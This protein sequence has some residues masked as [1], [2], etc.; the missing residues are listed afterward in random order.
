MS[1]LRRTAGTI[2]LA[3][4]TTLGVA[5]T[6]ATSAAA[7]TGSPGSAGGGDPYFPRAG[8][9]GYDVSHYVVHIGYLPATKHLG[10]RALVTARAT[11]ALSRFDLD[12]RRNLR[13]SAVTVN[14]AKARF[15]QPAAQ[16]QELVVTPRRT[17]AKGS[18][19]RVHVTYAGTAK[20]VYDPDGAIDGFIP[21]DDGALVAS[22]PQGAPTWFPVNDTPRDKATYQV[23]ITVPKGLTAVSNGALKSHT[24]KGNR[25]TWAWKLSRPAS[26]YLITACIGVFRVSQ[27]RAAGVPYFV[28][29][30]PSQAKA[31]APV[32][33]KLPAVISYFSR[34]YGA[35]P[36]G[37]TGVIVDDKAIGYA[38]ETVTRPVFDSAPDVDTLAHELAHQWYGDD[39]TL[40][41]WRDIW[42]NEGFAEFSTW[43]WQQ[44][45][46]G[47]TTLKHLKSL[48]ARP[49]SDKV[50]SPAPGNPGAAKNIFA[51]SVYTRGA[52]ALAALRNKLGDKVFFAIMRGWLKQHAYGNATVEQFTAYAEKVARRDLTTFFHE[53][54]YRDAKPRPGYRA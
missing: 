3:A 27:G 38:L 50:W 4:L 5:G 41:R 8:N 10:G 37:T 14:G 19:F 25:T 28:A 36:W 17:I 43:L 24:T 1:S 9:G 51:G 6:A 31:A 12:L 32:V 23:S 52:G 15:A 42:L 40:S 35:Y 47:P 29:V 39:V 2:A 53:W 7:P 22:E 26:P 11:Q 16:V 20:P 21:S 18:T 44:H 46:G 45:T 13:V 30:D 33:A 34:V 48:L 49:A 54:L